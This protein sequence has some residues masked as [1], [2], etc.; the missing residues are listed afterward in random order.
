MVFDDFPFWIRFAHFINIIFITLLIRSGIEILSALPKLYWHDDCRPGTEWIKFTR[1]KMPE[2]EMW[3]S[4][5][6]EE[7]FSSWIALPG[8]RNLGLGRHWHF[9]SIAFWIANGVAY[10]VLLFSS[11]EW[12]R[13]VPSSL[14]IIPH[15]FHDA[16]LYASF[17]FPAAGHPYNAIQQLTYFIVVFVLGPFM[18]ATG[19]AMSP[20]IS[21]RFPRYPKIFRGRQVARSLH[22]LGMIGFILFIIIHLTMVM[23]E[24]FSENM[25]NIVLGHA[26][27]FGVAAGL[28][29][30]FAIA[31]VIANVWATGISLRR[32]RQIQNTLDK[33]LVPAKWILFRKTI[34][35]QNLAKSDISTFFRINGYPPKSEKYKRLS[36]NS[37]RDWKL[38]VFGLVENSLELSL[39]D[40]YLMRKQDQ[41]T[42]HYCIQGWT[43]IAEWAGVSMQYIISLCKPHKDVRYVVFR[44]YQYTDQDQFYEV[45]DLEIARHPQTILAY[46]M[47]GEPLNIGHGAPLRLRAETQLGY[48]MV[49]WIESIEFVSNYKNIGKGQGGHREDH[50]YYSPRA[51]I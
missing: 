15:A 47:N 40:L 18:I 42:E 46:E 13:L 41:V 3:I 36:E 5:D 25:G 8:H 11:D 27:S 50:M 33:I 39:S 23:A 24:R 38:K 37:F 10:Y 48:K 7:S 22:F 9:F 19:A 44:S 29:A 45:L 26:T 14:S 43:A 12:Q 32:P 2:N 4:L 31:V 1:K 21:A 16:M 35:K 34:S 28:F 17:H 49:K 51:E 30:L 6:E 20:A